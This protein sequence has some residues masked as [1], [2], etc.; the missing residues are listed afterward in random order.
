[1]KKFSYIIVNNSYKKKY[2]EP[3]SILGELELDEIEN[4]SDEA[5]INYKLLE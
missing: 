4:I 2:K 5:L 1:M 3:Y